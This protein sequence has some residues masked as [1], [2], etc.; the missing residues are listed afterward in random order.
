MKYYLCQTPDGPQYAHLQTEAKALDPN[1]QTVE[2]DFSKQAMMKMLN[3]LL[4]RAHGKGGAAA[5][6]VAFSGE[7]GTFEEVNEPKRVEGRKPGEPRIDPQ[8]DEIRRG[9]R[10]PVCETSQRLAQWRA[11]GDVQTAIADA[12]YLVSD[13]THLRALRQQIDDQIKEAA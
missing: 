5:L 2:L 8:A 10:C 12:L 13:P 7:I 11:S 6:P 1:F 3:D 9:E 4:R